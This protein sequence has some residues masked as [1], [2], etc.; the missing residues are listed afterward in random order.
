MK[1]KLIKEIINLQRID[2][3]KVG[4]SE[5]NIKI[6]I[7]VPLLEILG[8]NKVVDL[9]FERNVRN[10]RADVAIVLDNKVKVIIET[11]KI[12]ERLDN[13]LEQ[14]LDYAWNFQVN[15]VVL[16]NGVEI[17]I[18]KSFIEGIIDYKDRLIFKTKL[19]DLE[20]SFN[21]LQKLISKENIRNEENLNLAIKSIKENITEKLL[22]SDLSECRKKLYSDLFEQLND[23]YKYN[24]NFKKTII[25]WAKETNINIDDPELI[26]KLCLEG[27]YTLINRVLFLRILEDRKYI[28]PKLDS[29]SLEK[30]KIMVEKTSSIINLAF[31]EI[32][33]KFKG[34]YFAPLFDSIY[35][36][37]IDWNDESLL[38]L[39]ERL[40]SHNFAE[41]D[42]D[43]IGKTYEK[44]I[45]KQ[46]RKDLGQFYTPDYIIDMILNLTLKKLLKVK[47]VENIKILDLACGSGGFLMKAYDILKK[48]YI[49]KGLSRDTIH[50]SILKNN[51][52]GIDINP[53]AT[54]LT[55]MNL[56]LKDLE[57]IT[58]EINLVV[59]DSLDRRLDNSLAID[60]QISP[61]SK[62]NNFDNTLTSL[63]S[64][65]D[66]KPFDVIVGNP[67]YIRVQNLD[68]QKK[69][70]YKK[71]YYSATG[72][73]DICILF[74]ERALELLSEEG[75][76]GFIISSKFMN[77][78]YGINIRDYIK[79]NA[80]VE[81]IIDLRE[82]NIFEEATTY[83]IILILSKAKN[84]FNYFNYKK[85]ID[86]GSVCDKEEI[87]DETK[88]ERIPIDFLQEKG[89]I[90]PKGEKAQII[91]KL[92]KIESKLENFTDN[93]FQGVKTG[94]DNIFILYGKV[95]WDKD[96]SYL[97]T[98]DGK[99]KV[100]LESNIL[101]GLLRGKDI[102]KYRII[103][104]NFYIIFPYKK[105]D[106]KYSL[107][108]EKELYNN[109]NKTFEYLR[110]YKEVLKNRDRG[111]ITELRWYGYSRPQNLLLFD[112]KKIITPF[113]SFENLFFLDDYNSFFT[114]GISGGCGIILKKEYERFYNYFLAILNSRITE[115]YIKNTSDALRGNYYS[116][117]KRFIK[118]IPII[119]NEND[120]RVSEIIK[121]VEEIKINIS[122][123]KNILETID[124]IISDIYDVRI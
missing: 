46:E 52:Y 55:V 98:T 89:W 41:I 122:N 102:R 37:D 91:Q 33:E 94:K 88:F 111:K 50:H 105:V 59:G 31:K 66:Y 57:N 117:E 124:K 43:I 70:I 113:N 61:L 18:Y 76:I 69:K 1:N 58:P 7:T 107:Y 13:H 68:E 30:L 25:N 84:K 114:A 15:W 96:I 80:I 99:E 110:K 28:K 60:I 45:N 39:L 63:K 64:V 85:F 5:E 36:E 82:I 32:G 48:E 6:K 20:N 118:N 62:I 4:I 27:V 108:D 65:L 97:R 123:K 121:L 12:T 103:E 44:H 106:D 42:R 79:E 3:E 78:N 29:E 9:D 87:F 67:P 2:L 22:I 101:K 74:L 72:S 14:A 93:I 11:K 119:I 56:F 17:R 92:E 73:Y 75:V 49:V 120:K 35:L 10:K 100:E 90:F 54:Q 83:P 71:L 104:N 112:R 24:D 116:F 109:F 40:S 95:N 81:D 34:L 53:F 38:F 86:I 47:P 77:S 19:E 23:R 115:F 16:T 21:N 26:E 8:Y 51:I